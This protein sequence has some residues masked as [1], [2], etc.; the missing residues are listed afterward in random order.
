MN[1][2]F[3]S[4]NYFP[5]VSG[6]SVVVKYLAEGLLA[7]GHSVAIATAFFKK[8]PLEDVI[9]GVKVFR[10][11]M[12][13]DWKHC[14]KGDIDRY[15]KFVV[16]YEADVNI[17]ECSQCITTDVLLPHLDKLRGKKLFHSHGFSGLELKPFAIKGDLKHTIGNTFNW[18]QSQWYF[19]VTLKKAMP[20]FDATMCLSDVD[21]SREYLKEFSK[22]SYILDNAA[23]DMFFDAS[24]CERNALGKYVTLEND[25]FI[26]SCANYSFIKNQMALITQYYLSEVS[27]TTSLICIGSQAND[28]Y[29]ECLALIGQFE[30]EYGHRDAHLLYGVERVDI[31]AIIN[32]ACLYLVASRQE[33]YSISIIEAM[34]QGVPF[35]STNV[36]NARI[37]PGGRTINKLETMHVAIDELLNDDNGYKKYSE[38]GRKFSYKNCRISAVVDKLERIIDDTFVEA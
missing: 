32:K 25:R 3:L 17:F 37:L 6:V 12:W 33:Q 13:K 2:L 9:N 5:N 29:K 21:S 26:V 38:E 35:I 28:Y 15:I 18:L 10:F 11:K 34:S 16:D 8:E 14:Y 7:K 24:S 1:L 31:P 30:E 23:D 27:K 36:G 19:S 20:Y 4:Q 22:K